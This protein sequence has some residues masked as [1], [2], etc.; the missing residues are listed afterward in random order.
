MQDSYR[1]SRR[2]RRKVKETLIRV[3]KPFNSGLV[4][5]P[6]GEEVAAS[7]Q[8]SRRLDISPSAALSNSSAWHRKG[9]STHNSAE[10]LTSQCESQI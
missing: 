5:T 1:S 7:C 8:T 10:I 2:E 9:R 4:E 3:D 6:P